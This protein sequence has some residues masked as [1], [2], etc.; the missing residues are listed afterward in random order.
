MESTKLG[1]IFQTS[2][3]KNLESDDIA[4]VDSVKK[5]ITKTVKIISEF[6]DVVDETD[7][8]LLDSS[9]TKLPEKPIVIRATVV[10]KEL[11]E[12]KVRHLYSN[13]VLRLIYDGIFKT[14]NFFRS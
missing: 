3:D 7:Y 2:V 9:K 5:E 4:G 6:N 8:E 12:T 13:V 14:R 11:D 1:E 10:K